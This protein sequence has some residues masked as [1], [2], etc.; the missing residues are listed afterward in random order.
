MMEEMY[1]SEKK[2]RHP[3]KQFLLICATGGIKLEKGKMREFKN[4]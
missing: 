3:T 4:T 1:V 2:L